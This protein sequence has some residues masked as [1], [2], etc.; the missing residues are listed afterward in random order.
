MTEVS[1][2]NAQSK[3]TVVNEDVEY[4]NDIICYRSNFYDVVGLSGE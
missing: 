1:E 4:G 2:R 3:R